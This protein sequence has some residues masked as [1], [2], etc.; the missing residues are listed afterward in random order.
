MRRLLTPISNRLVLVS[1]VD[2]NILVVNESIAG[3]KIIF[4]EKFRKITTS[5][6]A[7]CIQEDATYRTQNQEGN[8]SQS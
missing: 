7:K 5:S 3:L 2:A 1:G 8:K 6:K 4:E